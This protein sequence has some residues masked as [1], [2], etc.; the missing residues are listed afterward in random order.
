MEVERPPS[1]RP[2]SRSSMGARGHIKA[3]RSRI[4]ICIL[5]DLL[6][7]VA[8]SGATVVR[9]LSHLYQL[10]P[11]N[12]F[13]SVKPGLVGLSIRCNVGD[14]CGIRMAASRKAASQ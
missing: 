10:I 11:T 14:A 8:R 4:T 2:Q 13:G 1:A 9:Q 12:G 5:E 6:L 3:A 7:Q